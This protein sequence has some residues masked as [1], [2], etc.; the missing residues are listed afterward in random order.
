MALQVALTRPI[1][2][3]CYSLFPTLHSMLK[4]PQGKRLKPFFYPGA[5]T[6]VSSLAGLISLAYSALPSQIEIIMQR[7]TGFSLEMMRILLSRFLKHNVVY[8]TLSLAQSEMEIVTDL[9]RV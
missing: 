8:N 4:T 9:K 7:M 2:S 6:A 3:H 1:I 5:K